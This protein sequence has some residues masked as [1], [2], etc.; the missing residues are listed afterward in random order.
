VERSV[1][2]RG[3]ETHTWKRVVFQEAVEADREV[4][5][6]REPL[7]SKGCL[8]QF[9]ELAGHNVSERRAG[10]ENASCGSRPSARKGKANVVEAENNLGLVGST[11]VMTMARDKGNSQATR[12]I[13]RGGRLDD[14]P[15]TRESQAGPGRKT[16]RLVVP[17]KPGNAGGG[18]G[19]HFQNEY[20]KG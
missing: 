15:A 14:Q 16:E 10:P 9:S 19:P 2:S 11:G 18:K 17:L 5:N 7:T 4:T 8:G 20:L 1:S 13:R 3:C 12:E 6:G